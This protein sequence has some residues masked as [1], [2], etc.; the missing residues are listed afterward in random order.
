MARYWVDFAR[1]GNPN[2]DGLPAWPR[3]TTGGAQVLYLDDPIRT[4]PVANLQTLKV[5]DAVYRQVRAA[6][7]AAAPSR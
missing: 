6:P 1:S 7:A 2:G 4:G 5:F 3:F